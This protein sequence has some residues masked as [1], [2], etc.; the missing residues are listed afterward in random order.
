MIID[1][2]H[3]WMP[4]EHVENLEKYLRPGEVVEPLDE[5]NWFIKA[6]GRILFPPARAYYRI[7]EHIRDLDIAGVDMAVLSLSCWQEWTTMATAPV[8]NDCMAEVQ[9]RHPDRFIGLAHVPPFEEG[10]LEELERAVKVLGLRGVAITTHTLGRYP[11]APE[12]RPFYAKV[13]ELDV[14]IIV[15]AASL[16]QGEAILNIVYDGIGHPLVGRILDHSLATIRTLTSHMLDDF[17]SLRFVH[18]HLGGAAF[19][20]AR[21]W[22]M[23]AGPEYEK[24]RPQLYFDT[25]PLG[26]SR[27]ALTCAAASH[28][29][30]YVMM[31][32][33]YPAAA[34]SGQDIAS[35]VK[36][37]QELDLTA[38]EKERILGGNAARVFK[39]EGQ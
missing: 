26:W 16:P 14:P 22:L 8:I 12:F 32:S 5:D 31:G 1:V 23:L 28:G 38:E 25:A 36:A 7:D 6:K 21:E 27:H 13:A 3:H 30:D 20:P 4:Q 10:A 37:I 17:P 24:Y 19:F 39:I 9:S 35:A 18:G 2:H 29:V 34:H 33:D 15:H 11:D